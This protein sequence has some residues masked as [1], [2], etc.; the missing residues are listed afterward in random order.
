[1]KITV[2]KAGDSRCGICGRRHKYMTKEHKIC[3]F[4]KDDGGVMGTFQFVE[5]NI[6]KPHKVYDFRMASIKVHKSTIITT[7]NEKLDIA[8][9]DLKNTIKPE[10][11]GDIL[12]DNR[13]NMVYVQ[14]P[15]TCDFIWLNKEQ[16]LSLAA[17]LIKRAN[18]IKPIVGLLLCLLFAGCAIHKTQWVGVTKAIPDT[19]DK[20]TGMRGSII[21]FNANLNRRTK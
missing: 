11:M 8:I 5:L 3:I 20:A 9:K 10:K 4:D 1:M 7:V 14:L 6:N 17:N 18:L 15:I 21:H 16:A 2:A 13:N 12:I 19:Y